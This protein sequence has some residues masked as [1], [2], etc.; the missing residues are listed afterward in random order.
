MNLLYGS[1]LRTLVTARVSSSRRDFIGSVVGTMQMLHSSEPS[2][3][4]P[5]QEKAAVATTC[6]S[7]AAGDGYSSYRNAAVYKGLGTDEE[8]RIRY[9]Y[10]GLLPSGVTDLETEVERAK[11][12]IER[13]LSLSPL[14][15]FQTIYTLIENDSTTA[16][17]LLQEDVTRYLPYIYTPTIGDACLNWGTL[18]PRPMGLYLNGRRLNDGSISAT[19]AFSA[20]PYGRKGEKEQ[21]TRIAVITDGA[22]ILG[23][24]D[25]GAHGAGIPIGKRIVYGACGIDPDLVFPVLFDVGCDDKE[26][27][28]SK[29]YIGDRKGR[30]RGQEYLDAMDKLAYGLRDA[31]GSEVVLH[32]EDISSSN[33]SILLKRYRDLGFRTFNDDIEMTSVINLAAL[34]GATR[35]SSVPA[36]EEQTFLFFGAG[37]ANLGCAELLLAHLMTRG[38]DLVEAK[39]RI[40]IMDSKGVVFDGRSSVTPDK[41][42]FS[43]PLSDLSPGGEAGDLTKLKDA[44]RDIRPTAIIGAASVG[45]AFDKEVLKAMKEVADARGVRPI[46]FAL[47]N[48]TSA[49]ECD[50]VSALSECN[51]VY[52]SG[53]QFPSIERNGLPP[54]I[55]SQANNCYVFPGIGLGL[56]N[57]RE[58]RSS[59]TQETLLDAAMA[60]S[61]LLNEEELASESVL[62][63]LTRLREVALKVAEA[64]L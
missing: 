15:A 24:G 60:I 51:A 29:L 31:Y 47:S 4:Q 27:R 23:L 22:R 2:S 12:A 63:S 44:I 8:T 20:W 46:I 62:P 61:N 34:M 30:L 14:S 10:Q 56:I 11:A 43:H 25:L 32:W 58:G 21:R 3:E 59:V 37:Q 5:N 16:F 33:A 54:L 19:S 40:W 55:P 7:E 48:P 49:A 50:Y 35:I 1:S 6:I 42:R 52:A 28:E 9:G 39:R 57:D 41:K 18:L 53:T 17:A 38:L 36:L 64:A 13:S 45:N 26:L